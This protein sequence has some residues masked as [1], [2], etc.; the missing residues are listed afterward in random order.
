MTQKNEMIATIS[1]A[2]WYQI[3]T[4]VLQEIGGG[5]ASEG[6]RRLKKALGHEV[7]IVGPDGE[8]YD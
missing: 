6:A 7:K 1:H 3:P 4:D 2:G 5:E 8:V